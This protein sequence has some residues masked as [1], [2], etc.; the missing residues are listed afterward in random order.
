MKK[1]IY[2][3]KTHVRTPSN[4]RVSRTDDKERDFHDRFYSICEAKFDQLKKNSFSIDFDKEK[5]RVSAIHAQEGIVFCIRQFE[6]EIPD[7][8]A[9]NMLPYYR[10]QLLDKG[11]SGLVLISGATHSGKTTTGASIIVE[12]LKLYGGVGI[13]VEDPCERP[14]EG[15]HGTGVC[16]QIDAHTVGGF[17]E[18][19]KNVVRMSPDII[20]LGEVRDP[21]SAQEAIR[22]AINGHLL[23]ATIHA[24]DPITALLR[25]RSLASQLIGAESIDQVLSQ[26]VAAILHLKL[27][28]KM[29]SYL[30]DVQFINLWSPE[31]LGYRNMIEKGNHKQLSSAIVEQKNKARQ[32]M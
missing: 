9:L 28:M 19:L 10:Q 21:E 3:S 16:Y 7:L 14:M 1:D 31:N 17:A 23:F 25:L 20:F 18:A 4:G 32:E 11:L 12:R 27:E 6:A 2:L 29:G 22:A 26:G 5:Y 30:P 15:P 8:A 24:E 13:T